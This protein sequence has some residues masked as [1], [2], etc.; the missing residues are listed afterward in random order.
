M[1]E[2]LNLKLSYAARYNALDLDLSCS[3]QQYGGVIQPEGGRSGQKLLK[4][5]INGGFF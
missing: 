3:L 4:G 2:R 1:F 5:P